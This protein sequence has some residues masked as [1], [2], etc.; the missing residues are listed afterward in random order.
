MASLFDTRTLAPLQQMTTTLVT[1]LTDLRPGVEQLETEVVTDSL[2]TAETV[3]LNHEDTSNLSWLG[4]VLTLIALCLL[5]VK[6]L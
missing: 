1:Q 4:E 5:M 2:E 6:S 3:W